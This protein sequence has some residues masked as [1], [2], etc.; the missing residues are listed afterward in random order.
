MNK[1]NNIEK[2]LRK[3]APDLL[4]TVGVCSLI[5]STIMA[6]KST[7]KANRILEEKKDS[8]KIEKLKSVAPCYASSA[9]LACAGTASIICSRNITKNRFTAMATAY[10]VTSSTLRSFKKN[11]EEVV[12]PEKVKI[13]KSKVANDNLKESKNDIPINNDEDKK[14]LFFDSTSGRYFRST[15]NDIDRAVN[16]LNKQMMNDMCIRLNDFYNEIGLDRIKIGEDLGW[17]IDKG[18]IEVRYDSTIADNDEPC[19][20]LDYELTHEIY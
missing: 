3:N 9:L 14:P 10:T 20:V 1:I 7:P 5:G 18:L 17:N 13:I 6:V 2:I 11:L 15:I 8:T 19:I 4:L 16:E 12:E